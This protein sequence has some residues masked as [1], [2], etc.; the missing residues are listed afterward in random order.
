MSKI[1]KFAEQLQDGIADDDVW[2]VVNSFVEENGFNASQIQHYNMFI[3]KMIQQV[4]DHF[5]TIK[6][7]ENN[8]KYIIEFGEV[9]CKSPKYVGNDGVEIKLFPTEAMQRNITYASQLYIDITITP[10]LGK[11]THHEKFYLGSIPTMVLSDL[12]NL[13]EIRNNPEKIGE[14]NEDFMDN[15]GYFIISPKGEI[16]A[17]A[18]A[19]KRVLVP[20][21]RSRINAV[22]VFMVARKQAP[23]FKF[24][25]EVRSSGNGIHTTTTILGILA[26]NKIGVVLPWIDSVEIPLG[27]LF[28]AL[29]VLDEKE[30]ALLISGPE[31]DQ[32]V[33]DFICPT[34]EYSYECDSAE[35]A[36][37]YI[38]KRG[39]KYLNEEKKEVKD[40]KVKT[41]DAK[42]KSESISYAQRLLS[43]ELFP[44][45]GSGEHTFADKA[46]YL[47]YM[48]QKLIWV[49]LGRSKTESRDHYMNK[50]VATAQ[51]LLGQQFYG[52]F[53][54]LITEI[55]NNT[56]KALKTGNNVN[57]LSWIKPSIITNA[58]NGAISGN[59]WSV[60]GPASKGI[61]QL[62][63]QFNYSAGISNTRK[64]TVPMAAEGGKSIE[65]R[66]LHGTHFGIIC[67]TGD[68]MVLLG[69]GVTLCRMDD[70]EGKTVMT[71]NPSTHELE[72]SG[73]YNFFSTLPEKLLEIT[74]LVG[75]KVRCTP[76]HPFLVM[77]PLNCKEKSTSCWV[78]AG[79]LEIGDSIVT[80]QPSETEVKIT[81]IANIEEIDPEL[82]YDFT[83]Y[84]ENHSFVANGMVTHQC[85]SDTPEGKKAGLVKNMAFMGFVTIGSDTAPIK[86]MVKI[87]LGDNAKKNYPQ[88]L[89]WTRVFLNGEPLGETDKPKEL[90]KTLIKARR[91]S[92][93]SAET[94]ISYFEHI[95]EI[96]L[97]IDHG[98]LCRP[99]FVVE[100]GK[101]LFNVK[102]AENLNTGEMSWTQLLAKGLVDLIDKAEE[103]TC[104]IV[105]Y[106]SD[107]DELAIT[108]PERLKL[109]THCEIH[110]SLMYGIG[111][112][113]IPFPDH[114]QCIFEDENVYMMNGS[115]KKIKHVKVGD[116]VMNFD[117]KT[118]ERG[119]ATVTNV[120]S[121][122]TNKQMWTV[123][124]STATITATYDHRFITPNG[125][126]TLEKLN[127]NDYIGVSDLKPPVQGWKRGD[128]IFTQILRKTPVSKKAICDI[129]TD[130]VHQ[131]FFCEGFGVHNSPRNCYQCIWKEEPVLMGDNTWKKIK[132]IKIGDTVV[133]FNPETLMTST[134]KVVNHF[135]KTTNKT[136]IEL[137][138]VA[139]RKIIVT[140]DHKIMTKYGWQEA[141]YIQIGTEV[142]IWL[143]PNTIVHSPIKS[144]TVLST[145]EIADITTESE[146][147]SFIAG[148]GFCVH[149]S[150]MGKQAVGIPFTNYRQIMCGTFHTLQHMQKPLCLSRA[151]SIIRFDEL[152]AGQVAIV[153]I[154][155]RSF[156]EEDSIEMNEDSIQRGFMVSYKWTC[157]YSEIREE[158]SETFGI[159]SPDI[160]DRIKGNT[161]VLTFEGFPKPGTTLN[162]GDVVI[163]KIKESESHNTDPDKKRKYIDSSILYDH[164]W[165]AKVDKVQVGVTGD[166]YKYIRVLMCQRR[167]PVVGDKFCYSPD[168]EVLTTEGWIPITKVKKT[169]EVAT[170]NKEGELEYQNPTKIISFD[171][172]GQMVVVDTN[173]VALRVTPN[174]KMY[175]RRRGKTAK[176][177]ELE[178]A[179][180]LFDVHVHY[181]KDAIWNAPG[182]EEFVLPEHTRNGV[183]KVQIFEERNLPI[184]PWL[185]FFGIWMA[186]GCADED[187]VQI[188][189]NKERV[190]VA[191]RKALTAMGFSYTTSNT[192]LILTISDKQLTGYMDPLSVKAINKKMPDWVWKLSKSQCRLLLKSMC[193]GDG[194]MNGNTAM[195][196]TSS[197]KLKDDVMRLALHCG[198]AANAYV[199]MPAG[200][201]RKIRGKDVIANADGW[202]ITIVE[203]QLEPAVNKH[204]K[205]QQTYEDYD[206]KVYCLTVPN[207]VIYVRR[208]L[209]DGKSSQKP[210]WSGNSSSPGQKGTLGMR[211]KACDLPFDS[212]GIS[213]DVII[214]SLA[215]PSRMTIAMLLEILSGKVIISSSPLHTVEVKEALGD[216]SHKSEKKEKYETKE[217]SEKFSKAFIS[218]TDPSCIDATPFRKTSERKIDLIREEM[219][220]YGFDCGEE[221]MTDGITG[222]RLRSLVFFGPIFYQRLKHMSVDKFHARARGGRTTLFRQPKDY[223]SWSPEYS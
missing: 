51:V 129:T 35:K 95:K 190:D 110:P 149:N 189:I 10:P 46:K 37:Y 200:T 50:R 209:E 22:Q 217:V 192:G 55:S 1:K 24:Y 210:V 144:K 83:T 182:L 203:T 86:K 148:Q 71:V 92:D 191:I 205:K 214:N 112:S 132:D 201:V 145:L 165:P 198:W 160:C 195:Y 80:L 76:E 194:H 197:I 171:H 27:V 218:P 176:K 147:H 157:Y 75:N 21:E 4:I 164:V 105:G 185:T 45:V 128:L 156:N 40:S 48:T 118:G 177:Y 180:N 64:L 188:A 33:L 11:P 134:T 104:L 34:L 3:Y 155:P 53:R 26:G 159:P 28:R 15:G 8:K 122:Q 43:V 49:I 23:K 2:S 119:Y 143:S 58:M 68:T 5:S 73:I 103:E 142:A 137:S 115:V 136:I 84:S 133:S 130:S 173:Q 7:E 62:Y 60:G 138:T 140:Q 9:I 125:W 158:H 63:E 20:Q 106:P 208:T 54:K 65:P 6:I 108:N 29:G 52:A 135:V 99:L 170:L 184:K 25:A 107:L 90:I 223:E 77:R 127:E 168:H 16:A 102:D 12:C 67:V 154:M 19:Q 179:E 42:I 38:G 178:K 206:G 202:R 32:E 17:G 100:D 153:A 74:D 72:P 18:T 36:F 220:K 69:D 166:G 113:I 14:H 66:D 167:E 221:I 150:S 97:A 169:H 181:K 88:S 124:T 82:V 85:P 39:R 193:L 109:I 183:Y 96:Q 146:N 152:P 93:L 114:N 175:V 117:P 89:C 41:S 70:I 81:L 211:K 215:L 131:S 123:E 163:G 174:H 161:S 139:N 94:S 79:N 196:D 186:E 172:D 204:I 121:K 151:G 207:H 47:G 61:S 13:K 126:V 44:H 78:E 120:L 101:M 57:I 91:N 30:M 212:N 87:L 199:K 31:K 213:P 56:K 59:A 111:G 222:E 216:D 187:R 219:K 162:S 141:Q 98:R 116:T